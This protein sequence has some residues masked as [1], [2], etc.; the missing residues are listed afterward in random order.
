MEAY[1]SV[2]KIGESEWYVMK[3][4]WERSPLSG[5]DIIKAV[6]TET[7]WSQS[8]ILTM[9]RRLV[10]KKAVG[11]RQEGVMMY[12]PLVEESE[13][14]RIETDMFLKRVY[15]GSVNMLVKGFLE[16]GDL[17]KEELD[18]LKKLL[19]GMK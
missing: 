3:A 6:I 10:K 8:T 9:V 13:V 1:M 14:R 15:K 5:S 4:L 17:S 2:P 18:E 11:V 7:D 12:Y 16:S 19:D